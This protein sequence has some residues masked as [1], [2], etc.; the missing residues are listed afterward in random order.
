MNKAI[1]IFLCVFLTCSFNLFAKTNQF[2]GVNWADPRDN[3]VNGNLYLSGISEKDTYESAYTIADRVIGEFVEKLGTNSVRLPIN[4][5]TASNFWSTYTGIIDAALTKGRVIICYWEPGHGSG[6]PNM[7]K[8]WAMWKTVIDKYGANPECYFEVY[9]EPTKYSKNDLR[10]I[11]ATWLEKFSTIPHDH[12]ILDGTGMAQN[13]PEIGDDSRFDE[14]LLAVHDYSMWG[15]FESEEQ[16]MGHLSGEVGKYFERTICTEWGG[17]MS[18]GT[19]NGE[20]FDYQDYNKPSTNY[21]MAYIRGITEQLRKWEM[22]SFYWVG[23][24]DGDWYSMTKRVGEG[25]N[26][27]LEIVNQSGVDRMHYSWTDTVEVDPVPQEAFGSKAIA[28]PAKIEAENYDKPGIGKGNDS[29]YDKDSKNQGNV[30]REDAV[31]I[32]GLG[33]SDTLNTKDCKGYAIGYTESGEWLEYSLS[34]AKAGKY[35]IQVNMATAAENAGV[36]LSVDGKAITDT[37]VATQGEDWDHYEITSAKSNLEAGEFILKMAVTGNYVN[38]D[39]INIC[40]GECKADA[41]TSLAKDTTS[42]KDTTTAISNYQINFRGYS[43][44]FHANRTFKVYNMN[45]KLLGRVSGAS[46]REIQE[47]VRRE[48]KFNGVYRVK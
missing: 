20:Y 32:V 17:A 35:E 15:F 11:Y 42:T 28:L 6:I 18:P 36:I 10:N 22:G 25:A 44:D 21:F 2:R 30:Y 5:S 40:E 48:L 27:S 26:T 43:K 47:K 8:F 13:V 3:F 45:G 23:L 14:C 16:W 29:F 19:K 12:V 9:N 38:I 33:C 41:D 24:R 7:D 31:D 46:S 39:W 1:K 4:E 34:V 37:L